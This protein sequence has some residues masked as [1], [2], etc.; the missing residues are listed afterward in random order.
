M[1]LSFFLILLLSIS[2]LQSEFIE[3]K[4]IEDQIS[5]ITINRPKALNALNSKV[6]EELDQTLESIDT[7]KIR[8]V[9]I[10]GSG[11]KSFVVGADIAEMS[12]LTKKEGET[13]SKKGNDVFRKIETFE[14]PVIAAVNGFALGGG[15]E[16]AMSCDMI[17]EF[18]QT[19]QFLANLK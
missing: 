6:L 3:Y 17:S 8:T 5:I 11:E 7:N 19:M 12:T 16:L 13:F 15:C 9:I 14:I 18:V 2:S 10:T 4:E 1:K